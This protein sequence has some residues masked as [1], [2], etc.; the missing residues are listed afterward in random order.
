MEGIVA[1]IS[2]FGAGSFL[3]QGLVT[4]V[5]RAKQ[6]NRH[7]Q[8]MTRLVD[9]ISSPADTAAFLNSPAA[10]RLFEGALDRRTLVLQRVL[11]SIQS[12]IV[13]S[14]L[15]AAF[16]L[17]RTQ[18]TDPDGQLALLV[19]GTLGLALGVAF[20][21]AAGASYTLSQRWGLLREAEV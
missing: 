6:I 14:I 18:V 15:G 17:I 1:I 20:L 2:V 12:G 9:K 19:F 7:A 13:L 3:V 21:L 8:V 4:A 5:V 11:L 16:F 10:L